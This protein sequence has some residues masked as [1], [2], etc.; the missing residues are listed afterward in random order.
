MPLGHGWRWWREWNGC[1]RVGIGLF[2][3]RAG[4]PVASPARRLC[5]F[6]WR[7]ANA[8][9]GTRAAAAVH[10]NHPSQK[11]TRSPG[12]YHT[13][14][15]D[16]E[17]FGCNVLSAR[18]AAISVASAMPFRGH[19]GPWLRAQGRRKT[20]GG[21][22]GGRPCR[23]GVVGAPP[24]MRPKVIET[25]MRE[26][27]M[28]SATGCP[29]CRLHAIMPSPHTQSPP[30]STPPPPPPLSPALPIPQ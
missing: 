6:S 14:K 3:W 11:N 5:T 15:M 28:K 17:V 12:W 22:R 20:R 2:S 23:R 26:A 24:K 16:G 1:T 19:E 27:I 25:R 30:T 4:A 10:A 18:V 9:Q 29:I 7:G 13:H 21:P 8:P